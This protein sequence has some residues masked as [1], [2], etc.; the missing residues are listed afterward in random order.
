[1]CTNK[2]NFAFQIELLNPWMQRPQ[3]PFQGPGARLW[4]AQLLIKIYW[5]I[6]LYTYLHKR[7]CI[8]LNACIVLFP[9]GCSVYLLNCSTDAALCGQL[10]VSGFPSMSAFRSLAGVDSDCRSVAETNV[11]HMQYHGV[12]KVRKCNYVSIQDCGIPYALAME[13]LSHSLAHS[14]WYLKAFQIPA[15]SQCWQMIEKANMITMA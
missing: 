8:Y 14:Y 1:M 7:V 3:T 5:I 2:C 11:I 10:G 4:L 13:I 6:K 15:S 12:L 9:E